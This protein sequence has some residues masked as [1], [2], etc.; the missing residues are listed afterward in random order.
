MHSPKAVAHE[1]KLFGHYFITI[2]HV[3]PETDGTDDSCGWAWPKLN[4][5]EAAYADRLIDCEYDNVRSWFP[6]VDDLEAKS[7]IRR[8]FRFHKSVTRKWWQHP[9]WH[10]WHWWLQVHPLQD[11]K[12]WAFSR[13]AGCGKG[14]ARGRAVVSAS[15]GSS[16]PMWFKGEHDVWHNECFQEHRAANK[17]AAEEVR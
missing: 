16:G 17:A 11:F 3:D 15:W 10:V 4:T 7:H 9:R 1:I 8:T 6:G 13:C 12:R 2:W 14:F 5:A